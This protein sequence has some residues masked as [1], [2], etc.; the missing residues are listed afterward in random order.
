MQ[1]LILARV[2]KW[3]DKID[4]QGLSNNSKLTMD[5]ILTYKDKNWSWENISS[6]PN[7]TFEHVA[8]YPNF[9]WSWS[10]LSFNPNLTI[11]NILNY[12]DQK[13]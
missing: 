7:I 12:P 1:K 3:K 2:E 6:K 5:I 8:K 9:P 13:K 10:A 4:F 11:K